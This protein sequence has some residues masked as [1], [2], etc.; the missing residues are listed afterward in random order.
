MPVSPDSTRDVIHAL[1]VTM[2]K[3]VP[4]QTNYFA[5][6]SIVDDGGTLLDVA[7]VLAGKDGFLAQ[8]D[9][10]ESIEDKI[11]VLLANMGIESGSDGYETA[12][13]FFLNGLSEGT[14]VPSLILTAVTALLGAGAESDFADAAT[15][16]AN[17]VDVAKFYTSTVSEPAEDLADLQAFIA[18]VTGD[19][20]SVV[21]AK[22]A[23]ETGETPVA[24]TFDFEATGD[25]GDNALTGTAGA[26]KLDGL[27]GD[28]TLT[29]NEGN[30]S[31]IGGAGA[32]LIDAGAGDDTLLGNDGSD[33]L[34][35]GDGIDS[36]N[37]G[38]GD[39]TLTGGTG[40]DVLSGDDGDDLLTGDAGNDSL[41]GVDGDDV[42]IGSE[43]NDTLLGGVG[44]D[45]L[46]GGD[47][48]DALSGNAGDDRLDGGV[49]ADT[50]NGGAGNDTLLG[51]G[52]ADE[53]TGELG[54]DSLDGG[55][56]A[57]TLNGG[58]DDDTLLG[59]ADADLLIGDTGADSLDGG[60]GADTLD[61][62]LDN[63]TIMGGLGA[64]SLSGGTG[65][66]VFVFAESGIANADT[67]TDFGTGNDVIHLDEDVFD[68]I[69][70]AISDLFVTVSSHEELVAE[71]YD[72]DSVLIFRSDTGALYYDTDGATTDYSESDS[73]SG[74]TYTLSVDSQ[75]VTE[76]ETLDVTVATKDGSTVDPAVELAYTI[77]GGVNADD[78]GGTLTGTVS[79]AAGSSSATFTL[80]PAA[81]TTTE[82]GGER[83]TITLDDDTGASL[84]IRVFDVPA[85]PDGSRGLELIGIFSGTVTAD[86]IVMV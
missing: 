24:T 73:D 40:D 6:Q 15:V 74:T 81:D 71:D 78:F 2:F 22:A 21:S 53:L 66:D 69:D 57:D 82:A 63:D 37:G 36:L 41:E 45:T 54:N 80:S 1:V 72:N 64:D 29:G 49:G 59:G 33:S 43:G 76:G 27:A 28:D 34:I 70:G 14:P 8:F 32:D 77:S 13:T 68:E 39:D 12:E 38:A 46:E 19:P 84:D 23:I 44:N 7:T 86:D 65:D 85:D 26:D 25:S 56:G 5:L 62:S 3:A 47:G 4:G 83:A 48:A 11:G 31:L 30:D 20:A 10:L 35:G 79:I 17:K 16:L 9:G 67:I 75:Q 52:D 50:L 55:A 51:G 60:A 18:S 61:G 42:L 58:V